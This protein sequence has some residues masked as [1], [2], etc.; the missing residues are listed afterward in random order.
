MS[1]ACQH[2]W[3]FVDG[4][5]ILTCV[6]CGTTT[7][8]RTTD[9]ETIHS[10]SYYCDRPE[11]I[12]AQRDELRE[13]LAQDFIKHEVDSA[14][15]WSEWVCPDPAQY[16]M[17]CCDCGLVHEMQFNVV[18]YSA[19]DK[20]EDVDDPHVQAVFRARRHEVAEKP[21]PVAWEDV[22]GAI[23]RGW[24]HPEN[25]RKPMYVQL[26][27]AIAKEIQDMYTIPPAAQRQPLTD[28]K[29]DDIWNRYCDEMG[30]ASINDAYDIARAIEAA[31][32]ITG[33]MT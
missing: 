32:G 23:A 22:L 10:C 8:T 5:S 17:K 7:G 24:A 14:S 30:E 2:R 27:V 15:D 1:E 19:G 31:H 29:I 4:Q 16:F 21:E 11:C 25:A 28:E 26:A 6:K 12:K 18:K 20:C 13:R 3:H 9:H 33:E